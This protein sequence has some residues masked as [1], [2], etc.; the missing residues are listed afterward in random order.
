MSDSLDFSH[1]NKTNAPRTLGEL[2]ELTENRPISQA[3]FKDLMALGTK[4]QEIETAE[5]PDPVYKGMANPNLGNLEAEV[6]AQSVPCVNCGSPVPR[7]I[8]EEEQGFCVDCQAKYY[9]DYPV[10]G[11]HHE[12]NDGCYECG[13]CGK[14]T[15]NDEDN[16]NHTC[17]E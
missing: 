6:G 15:D 11:S 1:I 7:D 5:K 8:H 4:R 16:Q 9:N 10:V 13:V 3:Q 14:H 12:E 2:R 17:F